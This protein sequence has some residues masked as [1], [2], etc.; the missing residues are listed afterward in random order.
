M[1]VRGF[2]VAPAELEGLLLSHPDIVDACVVGIRDDYSGEL[3][4]AFVVPRAGAFFDEEAIHAFLRPKLAKYKWYGRTSALF[5]LLSPSCRLPTPPVATP[6]SQFRQFVD[7]FRQIRSKFTGRSEN[8]PEKNKVTN[9]GGT[10]G[11]G[12]YK[13]VPG[14]EKS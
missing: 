10:T 12:D 7:R 4:K 9:S 13:P 6:F 11:E 14:P 2:Q 8:F 5:P 3:P 1:Q